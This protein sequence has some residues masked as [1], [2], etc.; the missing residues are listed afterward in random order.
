MITVW[1]GSA[2]TW[3]CDEMGHMN[4]RVY[5]EKAMEGMGALAHA[6]KT[7]HAF[8]PK[9]PSTLIPVDQ[10][11]RYMREVHAGRPISMEACLLEVGETD[12]VVYQEMRHADGQ[13]AAAFRTRY[14]HAEAKS[15]APFPWSARSRA[16]MEA[17][18]GTPPK[19][20]APRSVKWPGPCLDDGQTTIAEADRIGAPKIG[21]GAVPPEHLDVL[22]R[23]RP[24]WIMGRLSDSVPSLLAAWRDRVAARQGKAR[25]G[26][27][28]L[29]Y[30]LVYRRWPRAGDLFEVRTGLGGTGEKTHSLVHWVLDPVSGG[31]WA[32]CEAVA[33]TFDIE[34]R[35]IIPT[36][37]EQIAELESLAPT[38]LKV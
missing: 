17:L 5:V 11:I 3:D 21:V 12:M 26:G 9:T 18:I 19:E 28:V 36:E 13:P 35:K 24:E 25:T 8:R 33:V 32:T 27:A 14:V 7:P 30:R 16:A 20:T 38:G 37:P 34:S 15:G 22:G 2:N 1:Q 6:I 10:H 23:M 29:E 31:A 4:V